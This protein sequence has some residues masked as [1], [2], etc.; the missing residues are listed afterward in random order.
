[1]TKTLTCILCPNGCRITA[2]EENGT[3]SFEGNRCPKGP[4]Y[5]RQ[6]LTAPMRN[7]AS[8]V[9]VEG[10]EYPLCSVRLTAPIPKGRIFEAMDAIRS[11]TVTAPVHIGDVLLP[12]ILGLESDVI[13][14]RNVGPAETP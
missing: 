9:L 7:I 10:G 12:H 11:I 13:A 3:L 5:V 4:E 6:E 14:T 1:M 8:S 2:R